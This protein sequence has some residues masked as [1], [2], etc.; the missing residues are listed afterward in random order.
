MQCVTVLG[1]DIITAFYEKHPVCRN[2]PFPFLLEN[3][4][5][6]YS[7]A[8]EL[9]EKAVKGGLKGYEIRSREWF[10]GENPETVKP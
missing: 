2:F 7:N 4:S 6:E 8:D 1:S 10:S 9:Y 5:S 3:L